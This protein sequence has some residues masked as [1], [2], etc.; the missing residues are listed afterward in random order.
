MEAFYVSPAGFPLLRRLPASHPHQQE[1]S[2]GKMMMISPAAAA[3]AVVDESS[4]REYPG[5]AEQR[6]SLCL[7]FPPTPLV[8][9]PQN[10][11][12]WKT[13]VRSGGQPNDLL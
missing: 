7:S 11:P 10:Q 6:C 8:T 13:P 12:G 5:E 1:T 2:D 9:E 3:A 4:D